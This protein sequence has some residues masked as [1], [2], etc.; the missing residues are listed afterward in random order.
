MTELRQN[1]LFGQNLLS[2]MVKITYSKVPSES[3]KR[4]GQW[5]PRMYIK[6]PNWEKAIKPTYRDILFFKRANTK[7]KQL[8]NKKSQQLLDAVIK[9]LQEQYTGAEYQDGVKQSVSLKKQLEEMIDLKADK[10]ESTINGYR[11][12]KGALEGFCRDK[13]YS[14]TMDI[15]R[16][17]LEFI[18][19]YR[20]WLVNDKGYKGDTAHKYFSL[21]GGVLKKAKNYGRLYYNPFDGDIEYPKKSENKMVYLTG[22]EVQ[23]MKYTPFKYEHI[24]NAFLF[25]CH[26]GIRQGDC[27]KLTWSDLPVI[28]GVTKLNVKTQKAKTDIYFK[29]PKVALDLLPKRMGDADKV[30]PNLKFESDTNERLRMWAYK[31]GVKKHITPHTARHTFAF[32]M[33]SVNNTPLYTVSKLLGHTNARTTEDSYGHLSTENLD[34]AMLKAFGD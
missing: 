32:W 17:N 4:K 15:N 29:L 21:L 27:C 22:E 28:D 14:F 10:S 5:Y 25:M 3:T 19:K 11:N 12:L 30:F 33:L 16:I 23:K 18:D 1:K 31:S 34:E 8:Q 2:Y 7:G 13:G 24:K 9:E 6:S 26:T 20:I